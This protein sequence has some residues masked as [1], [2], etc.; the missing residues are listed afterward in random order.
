MDVE[1][2]YQ[3]KENLLFPF[4]EKHGITGPPMVMWGKHD[5]TRELLQA[6]VDTWKVTAD[7]SW[8]EVQ[9]LLE[10]VLQPAAKAIEEM[11]YKEEEILLPM[12][13]DTL[14]DEEWYEIQTQSPEIGFCL[15]DPQEEWQPKDLKPVEEMSGGGGKIRLPSGTMNPAELTAI[16]NTLPADITFVDKEDRV[17]FFSQGQERIFT[18]NRAIL[19]RKVQQCHPPTSVHV[20]QQIL[21]DFRSGTQDRAAFWIQ[22]GGQFVHIEY[23]ALRDETG[24]Y[25][26]TLEFSQDLTEKRR[27]QGEQRLL[28]YPK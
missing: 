25:L 27:L 4:L 13:L 1:K 22:R 5:E 19:G 23:F 2:H 26:G 24:N 16:L 9:T 28:S 8:E 12:S 17:R 7:I 18:R 21:D 11:I 3:R 14:T 20:V 10:L 6:A 15:Y